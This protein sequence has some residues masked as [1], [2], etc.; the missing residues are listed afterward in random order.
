[1]KQEIPLQVNYADE[2]EFPE[3]VYQAPTRLLSSHQTNWNGIYLEVH[4]TPPYETP[5]FSGHQHVITLFRQ[6]SYT[7]DVISNPVKGATFRVGDISFAPSQTLHKFCWTQTLEPVHL[8]LEPDFVAQVAHELID[9]DCVTLKNCHFISDPLIY[10]IV[11]AI[12]KQLET[13]AFDSKLYVESAAS[14]LSVHLLKHYSTHPRGHRSILETKNKLANYKINQGINYIE[15]HLTE[16]LSLETI[17]NYLGISRYHFCRIFKQSMGLS[18]HQYV[19]QQ[20]VE[21]AKRMLR[22]GNLSISDIAYACGFAHQSHFNYH[23]KKLTGV[24]PREFI[25]K[26]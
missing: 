20:R 7:E 15:A 26:I 18:P 2:D 19:I 21:K 10:Q 6:L 23:F 11:I 9:P 3:K 22:E 14:F 25:A 8:M 1:M 5:E 17:A 24:T 16:N 12:L 4:K 13:N